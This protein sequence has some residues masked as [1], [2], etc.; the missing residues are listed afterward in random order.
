MSEYIADSP[1][2][3]RAWCPGCEPTRD[4]E[5]EIL[6]V[7]FCVAHTP[8]REGGADNVVTTEGYV[9]GSTEAGGEANRIWCQL[10]HREAREIRL[11]PSKGQRYRPRISTAHPA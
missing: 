1:V 10:L 4:P 7:R 3:A 2:V 5:Q 11:A 8:N 9:S 6:D